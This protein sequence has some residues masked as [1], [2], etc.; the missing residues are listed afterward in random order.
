MQKFKKE[1]FKVVYPIIE[2][3]IH[4]HQARFDK[5]NHNSEGLT[6]QEEAE[7]LAIGNLLQTEKEKQSNQFPTLQLFVNVWYE[8]KDDSELSDGDV[9]DKFDIYVCSEMEKHKLT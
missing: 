1:D 7:F 5:K 8:L 4:I 6:I 3:L 2:T 9:I